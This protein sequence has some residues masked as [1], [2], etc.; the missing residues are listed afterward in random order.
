MNPQQLVTWM[1]EREISRESLAET[2]GRDVSY[3][4]ELEQSNKPIPL[5]V[6]LTLY[7]YDF[8]W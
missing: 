6:R 4:R 7:A 3:V 8:I 1:A 2:L 5:R